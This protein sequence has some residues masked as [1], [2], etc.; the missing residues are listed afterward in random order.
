MAKA[1][2]VRFT[3]EIYQ[4]LD[5]ASA[6]TGLPVNSIVIAACLEWM[7]RHAPEAVAEVQVGAWPLPAGI[8]P[9][10]WS[11]LNRAVKLAMSRKHHSDMYPFDRFTDHAKT[12][13][14][15]AQEEAQKAGFSYLGTEHLLIAAF[16]K[17]EFHSA[18]ILAALGVQEAEVRKAVV[19]AIG[20]KKMPRVMGIVPT[21]RVKKVIELAFAMCSTLNKPRVETGHILLAL[22][23]EGEGIAAHVLEDMGAGRMQIEDQLKGLTE[24]EA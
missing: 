15:L 23:A 17:P 19:Y 2:T 21:S 13:L 22:A 18:Q 3:D 16:G 7:Q 24:P 9:P 6:R 4:R 10:R 11:T 1:T 8:T 20:R 5:Q 14:T 12:L